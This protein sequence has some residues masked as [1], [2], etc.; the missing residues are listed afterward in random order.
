MKPESVSKWPSSPIDNDTDDTAGDDDDDDDY[1]ALYVYNV[2]T[3][4]VVK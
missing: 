4:S 2:E 3:K 1:P